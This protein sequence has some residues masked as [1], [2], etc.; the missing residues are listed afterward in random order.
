[1]SG[2]CLLPPDL[3]DELS[4]SLCVHHYLPE[5]PEKSLSAGGLLSLHGGPGPQG[6]SP[7]GE[8]ARGEAL[9]PSLPD[10]PDCP[11]HH[12]LDVSCASWGPKVVLSCCL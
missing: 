1:M 5:T 6:P 8:E 9:A 12:L 10:L 11:E 7:K 3:I 2:D 4:L